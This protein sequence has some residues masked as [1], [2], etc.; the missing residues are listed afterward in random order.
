MGSPLIGQGKSRPKYT[1]NGRFTE[2]FLESQSGS[3]ASFTVNGGFLNAA[4]S[5]W[6]RLLVGFLNLI[7]VFKEANKNLAFDFVSNK[8]LQNFKNHKRIY[9]KY[10]FNFKYG[11]TLYFWINTWTLPIPC[12]KDLGGLVGTRHLGIV[13]A[14]VADPEMVS[15]AF[16]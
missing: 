2:Q 5:F 16:L 10:W 8:D 4:T 11:F 12:S 13:L 1:C 14:N 7:S 9:R 3:G 15:G 6:T